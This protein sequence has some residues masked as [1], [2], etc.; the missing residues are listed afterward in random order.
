M[1]G[2]PAPHVGADPRDPPVGDMSVDHAAS[3]AIMAAGAGD[4]RLTSPWLV[5][6]RF[7]NCTPPL[8]PCG[9]AARLHG[10]RRQRTSPCVAEMVRART[11]APH[12]ELMTKRG[13]DVFREPFQL[14]QT[15]R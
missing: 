4:D 5:T 12:P 13:H 9:R 11:P 10:N 3:T 8:R 15:Q 6:R 2:G 7:I 1:L 14:L